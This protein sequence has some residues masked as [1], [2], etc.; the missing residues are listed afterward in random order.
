MVN[1]PAPPARH[2]GT[3]SWENAAMEFLR[4]LLL[5][6]HL[7]AFAGLLGSLLVQLKATERPVSQV[8]LWSARTVFVAGL[9]LVGVLEGTDGV[10]VNHAKIGVKLLVALVVV[11]LLEANAKKPTLSQALYYTV[12]GLTVVNVCVAVFWTAK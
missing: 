9:L 12:M 8:T 3:G 11:G 2:A 6:V 10:E 5:V 4:H 1:L 7:T